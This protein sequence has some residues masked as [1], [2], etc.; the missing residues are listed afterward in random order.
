VSVFSH[1]LPL[2]L[3]SNARP[4]GAR[5]SVICGSFFV[6]S[7]HSLP[8]KNGRRRRPFFA[9][10]FI[11]VRLLLANARRKRT[12]RINNFAQGGV[13]TATT[14][15]NLSTTSYAI[16]AGGN[17]IYIGGNVNTLTCSSTLPLAVDTTSN[18]NIIAQDLIT[19]NGA[20]ILSAESSGMVSIGPFISVCGGTITAPGGTL[21]VT[22][23]LHATGSVTASGSCCASDARVKQ[24]I[25]PASTRDLHEM[26]VKQLHPVTF[27][28]KP[29]YI[30]AE[31]A[32]SY[33]AR[34]PRDLLGFIAQDVEALLPQAV[35]TYNTTHAPDFKTFNKAELMP[36][37]V[38]AIQHQDSII[39]LMKLRVEVAEMEVAHMKL[40]LE[41]MEKMFRRQ[42]KK[43]KKRRTQ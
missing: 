33:A 40:R 12:G 9:G 42:M 32:D 10:P 24:N 36:V 35:A 17:D 28:W 4:Q 3:C 11:F 27:D 38:G 1:Y 19:T 21:T 13:F 20:Q 26:V 18:S 16:S 22:G 43:K 41:K 14:Q 25:Q 29:D 37:V 31:G 7:I 39:E 15:W 34:N 6:L 5:S 2:F 30:D 23:N 8:A